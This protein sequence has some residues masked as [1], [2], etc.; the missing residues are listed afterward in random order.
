[1]RLF[2][3]HVQFLGASGDVHVKEC[4]SVTVLALCCATVPVTRN[5]RAVSVWRNPLE[6]QQELAFHLAP[7]V[8]YLS[9]RD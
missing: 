7:A 8:V 2:F 9:Q 6:A 3:E 1:M 5:W 4:M